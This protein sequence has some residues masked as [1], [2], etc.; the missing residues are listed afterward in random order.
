MARMRITNVAEV[1][2]PE[3]GSV[4]GSRTQSVGE[5]PVTSSGATL[6]PPSNP[7]AKQSR[8]VAAR[9]QSL[10]RRMSSE[11]WRMA[12]SL[13]L[14]LLIHA[15]LLSL[16][17]GGQGLGL[18]GFG[19]P[20]RDRRIEV[21]ELRVVLVPTPVTTA[22]PAGR[23]GAPAQPSSSRSSGLLPVD[24]PRLHRAS[25]APPLGT[26]RPRDRAGGQT[27]GRGQVRT[28]RRGPWAPAKAPLRAG[29]SRHAAPAKIP[30]PAVIDVG[31]SDRPTS[32]CRPLP[33]RNLP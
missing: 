24:R 18:P 3:P 6:T 16:T 7:A 30:K 26:S 4:S 12:S 5:R 9:R 32:S 29:E 22:E 13:L 8:H 17:F 23:R 20:W 21:P 28:K 31:P 19:F 14:S 2:A 10:I 27:N 33:R 25:P 15:L 11:R 1:A